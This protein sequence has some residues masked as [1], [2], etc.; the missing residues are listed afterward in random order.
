MPCGG[1]AAR[2][3]G[4]G[5]LAG[6]GRAPS[7]RESACSARDPFGNLWPPRLHCADGFPRTGYREHDQIPHTGLRQHIP[8]ESRQCVGTESVC[9]QAIA[10]DALVEDGEALAAGNLAT[11]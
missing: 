7:F 10:A 11:R 1:S 6:T 9:Q 4:N 3:K 5:S 2:A 8:V